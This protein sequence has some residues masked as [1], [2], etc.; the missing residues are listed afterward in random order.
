[1]NILPG[2]DSREPSCG[3]FVYSSTLSTDVIWLSN[4]ANCLIPHWRAPVKLIAWVI[5]NPTSP[6]KLSKN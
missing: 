2:E 5:T 6:P 4:S 1:M 3:T